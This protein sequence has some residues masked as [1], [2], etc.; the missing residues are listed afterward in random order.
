MTQVWPTRLSF[1]RRKKHLV[2]HFDDGAKFTIPFELLRLESPS[3]EV[4]G[5]GPGQKKWLKDKAKI[6]VTEAER[7]GRYA[8]RLGFDD[9]HGS[10]IYSWDY[11]REL[12][13]NGKAMLK[14]HHSR[15]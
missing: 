6:L 3:A 12:G 1:Y 13:E 9:G 2:I 14:A 7:V 10:G 5:H 15:A 11:L 8:I 4:Q